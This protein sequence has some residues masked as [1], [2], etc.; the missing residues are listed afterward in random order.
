M[1]YLNVRKEIGTMPIVEDDDKETHLITKKAKLFKLY[2]KKNR[3]HKETVHTSDRCGA[4][5][6]WS[7]PQ[8]PEHREASTQP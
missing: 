5:A 4:K 2:D 7:H 8:F 1:L 6:K 3:N